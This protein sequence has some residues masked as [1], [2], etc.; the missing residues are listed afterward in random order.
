MLV[1]VSVKVN[2]ANIFVFDDGSSF[3][4]NKKFYK[5]LMR[6]QYTQ[7]QVYSVHIPIKKNFIL[8]IIHAYCLYMFVSVL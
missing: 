3:I 6:L 1:L 7:F 4:V 2:A 8:T 5:G